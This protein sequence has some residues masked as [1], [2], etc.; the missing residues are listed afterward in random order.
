M[1]RTVISLLLGLSSVAASAVPLTF[2]NQ[3]VSGQTTIFRGALGGIGLTQ[4]GSVSVADSNSGTGGSAGVFSGFDLDFAFLDLDGNFATAGDRVFASVFNF[5]TGTIRATA[6]PDFLPTVLRPGPTSGSS[7]VNAIDAGLSTLSSLDGFFPA[8]F[9]TDNVSGWLTLGDGGSLKLGF[10]SL[11]T[12][13]GSEALFLG[14]V[15]TSAG[16]LADGASVNVSS[17]P[18]PEPGSLALACVGLAGIGY[19]RRKVKSV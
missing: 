12:L 2:T 8:G 4:I 6:N 9:N 19:V 10:A 17:N 5:T 13:T 7:A 14:E 3:G 16:E 18:I 1:R 11:V 15:G